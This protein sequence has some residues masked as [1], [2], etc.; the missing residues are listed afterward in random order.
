ME[1]AAGLHKEAYSKMLKF[2]CVS[3]AVGSGRR[4]LIVEALRY[5]VAVLASLVAI[6]W[7]YA[8]WGVSLRDPISPLTEDALAIQA[9]A[10]KGGIE[11]PGLYLNTNLGAPFGMDLRDLPMPDLL[12]WGAIKLCGLFT[13]NHILVRNIVVLGSFPLMTVTSLY[14]MRRL[15]LGF[16]I[17]LGASL[18]F[19]FSAFHHWR[20]VAHVFMALGYFTVP[21][22]ALLAIWLSEDKPLFFLPGAKWYKPTFAN[23]RYT[24]EMLAWCVVMGLTGSVYFPFYTVFLLAI[25]SAFAATRTRSWFA[26][27]RGVTAISTIVGNL[28]LSFLP[29]ILNNL[30]NGAAPVIRR[31]PADTE[32]FG[33]K[34]A[35]LVLPVAGHKTKYLSVLGEYY[36]IN[37][38]L[39]NENR[40]SYL[41]IVGAVGLVILLLST[42]R[43]RKNGD[44][45][46]LLSLLA[47]AAFMYGTIGGFASL[48]SFLVDPTIRSNNR[49]CVYIGFFSLL[50][51]AMVLKPVA[52]RFASNSFARIG[53]F[54]TY[55][56]V[57]IAGL[58]DQ[59][60]VVNNYGAIKEAYERD[61]RFVKNIESVVPEGAMIFQYPYFPFPERGWIG[62]ISDY[63]LFRPYFHS[64]TLKWSFGSIKGRRGDAW[65]SQVAAL[66]VEDALKT[67]VFAGFSGVY[68]GRAAYPDGGA[69]L[70][71][72]LRKVIG[73]P[74]FVDERRAAS[75]FSLK[76][77]EE[78]LRGRL[79][80]ADYERHQN[81]AT[82]PLYLTW[83]DGFFPEE[84]AGH[85]ARKDA[86]FV[87]DNPMGKPRSAD[88]KAKII[89]A[90]AP[91]TVRISGP[92]LNRQ[93][94]V[95]KDGQPL[96]EQLVV[97]P[98][99]HFFRVETVD[100]PDAP[101]DF[102]RHVRICFT[103]FAFHT[104]K[105]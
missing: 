86:K 29:T 75:F 44:R 19:S 58:Y 40:T 103:D 81:E 53:L 32:R 48:F 18:L 45:M 80:S 68:V 98:G 60:S 71:A 17:S 35:Q 33:L 51:V 3:G 46:Q 26:L 65:Y 78:E 54:L 74:V 76:G 31:Y 77:L 4:D 8:L 57:V 79:S 64:R 49:I 12:I 15:G 41:G 89:V 6:W 5:L 2:A 93:F 56:V 94:V 95:T 82:N 105:K 1:P 38:L 47:L 91:A 87:I 30:E 20:S 23:N 14:V 90:H 42:L 43:A 21:V 101:Y 36:N 16:V 97:P 66:P 85:C 55:A 70:E 92:F 104:S 67:L 63:G 27:L 28:A 25:A 102:D 100:P 62:G 69:E 88:L 37:G 39:S 83:A 24:W 96:A 22:V 7:L 9:T 73:E 52:D 99:K 11:N 13:D 34:F 84:A 10:F 61:K 50:A 59:N 72:S